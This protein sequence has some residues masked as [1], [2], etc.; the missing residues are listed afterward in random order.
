MNQFE[1]NKTWDIDTVVS[2]MEFFFNFHPH[3]YQ[4][5]FLEACLNS[6]R[7]AGKWP[8]QSGKSTTVANY[9][10]F[11]A[12]TSKVSIMIIAPTQSQSGELYKKIRDIAVSNPVI[13]NLI[14]KST[15]TELRF[16]N[17]SRIL[18]LPCGP[19]GKTIRGYTADIEILEESGHLKDLIVNTVIL[20]MIASKADGQVIKIGTPWIRNHFYRSCFEDKNYSVVSIGWREVV[21][22][23]QYTQEFIDEQKSQLLDIEFA[24]EYDSEFIDDANSFF[25]TLLLDN[26]KLTYNLY[27]II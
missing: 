26:C 16:A 12:I 2:F 8:R 10:L 9:V 17:S 23:G 6:K 14:I 1:Q 22:A 15:E 19:D 11:K 7:I 21:S 5:R 3:P 20:P 18:S 24:T 4:R 25:P 27:P 13:D